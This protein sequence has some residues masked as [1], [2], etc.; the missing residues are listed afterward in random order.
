MRSSALALSALIVLSALVFGGSPR[1]VA[2]GT[3][4]HM[5]N[6]SQSKIAVAAGYLSS[7]PD[8]HDNIL[9]GPFVSTGWWVLAAGE[10][11]T[12][13]NPF[14]ARYMYYTGFVIGGGAFWSQGDWHFC[15]PSIYGHS[16]A[17]T[18][19]SQNASQ[20]A[21]TASAAYGTGGANMWMPARQ[22]DVEVNAEADYDGS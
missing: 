1:A 4:M 5:C 9:T 10:C 12:I 17:F 14:A 2:S 16:D 13:S 7:G 19:E 3:S 15:A 6:H 18:F 8:D 21:C 20:D 22:V 11:A